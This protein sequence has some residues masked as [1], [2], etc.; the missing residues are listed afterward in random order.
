MKTGQMTQRASVLALFAAVILSGCGSGNNTEG[1]IGAAGGYQWN[2]GVVVGQGC[3]PVNQP[4]SFQINGAYVDS[5]NI[6]G[7]QLPYAG[8][9]GQTVGVGGAAA[10]QGGQYFG[11]SAYGQVV[12]NTIYNGAYNGAYPYQNY[13]GYNS[14]SYYGY[15]QYTGMN[16]NVV[17]LQGSVIASPA[18]VNQMWAGGSFS[19]YGGYSSTGGLFT[20]P[21]AGGVIG[22]GPCVSNVAVNIGHWN[23]QL[24]GGQVFLYM[25]NSYNGYVLQF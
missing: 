11:Q 22:Q 4:I 7:G 10:M 13:P 19:P 14:G 6:L 18:M 24:Y 1:A 5:A 9:V 2:N 17:N 15:G 23:N 16:S 20:I 12:L 3:V 25:N 21:G 8:S